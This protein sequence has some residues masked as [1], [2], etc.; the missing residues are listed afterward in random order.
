MGPPFHLWGVVLWRHMGSSQVVGL[1]QVWLPQR[2]FAW[3]FGARLAELTQCG[4]C[5][6]C[7]VGC[8]GRVWIV[9]PPFPAWENRP[10][11]WLR[12]KEPPRNATI[13]GI[14]WGWLTNVP[15]AR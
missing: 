11:W 3:L 9:I 12:F 1:G 15:S 8:R 10:W 13:G 5:V 2:I 4:S 14:N 6:S 7:H